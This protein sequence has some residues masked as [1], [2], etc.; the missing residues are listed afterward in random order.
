MKKLAP[1]LIASAGAAAAFQWWQIAY[2]L[3]LF[4]VD[5]G[6]ERGANHIS[7]GDFMLIYLTNALLLVV[8]LCALRALRNSKSWRIFATSIGTANLLGWLTLFVMHRTGALVEYGEF[9]LHWRGE[10]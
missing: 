2:R 4:F 7:D 8:A 6:G 5:Y 10:F 3:R 9:I 1:L